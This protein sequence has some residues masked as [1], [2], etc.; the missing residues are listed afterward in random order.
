MK[1]IFMNKKIWIGLIIAWIVFSIGYVIRDRWVGYRAN[2]AQQ[3]EQAKALGKA[4]AIKSLVREVA[5]C[6]EVPLMDGEV[7]KKVVALECLQRASETVKENSEAQAAQNVRLEE[8]R[9]RVEREQQKEAARRAR[10]E[11]EE[12]E[13]NEEN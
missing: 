6:G 1:N 8:E 2:Q 3:V 13:E 10:E 7:T 4:D 11:V 9:V 5:K 12:S